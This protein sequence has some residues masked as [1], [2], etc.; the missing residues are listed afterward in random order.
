MNNSTGPDLAAAPGDVTAVITSCKRH[1]LLE[2]TLHS[3]FQTNDYPLKE[4]IIVEDS[5]DEGVYAV[6]DRF[7]DQP[8]TVILNGKNIGQ[9]PSI[10]RAYAQVATPYIL[11][12]EDDWEFTEPGVVR[13]AIQV[14]EANRDTIIVLLR[15]E[16]DMVY[17]MRSLKTQSAGDARY[18]RS[19]PELHFIWH[20]F[21][22]NP[23]LKRTADYR[24]LP[25][26]Y[27]PIGVESDI[28]RFYKRQGWDMAWL[29]GGGVRHIGDERSTFAHE[30]ALGLFSSPKITKWYQSLR[31]RYWHRLRLFGVDTEPM[32]RKL[33]DKRPSELE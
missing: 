8:I 4:I 2:R 16:A 27:T 20:T 17:Y 14:L 23:T 15:E 5:D 21:T 24:K 33:R 25:G 30:R 11:H 19:F 28:S 31:R 3:L 9:V 32:Q 7:P 1:D 12:M 6:R 29:C 13:K 10:D 22:F 18:K 26:G